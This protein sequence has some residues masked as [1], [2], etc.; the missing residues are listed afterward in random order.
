LPGPILYIDLDTTIRGDIT[1]LLDAVEQH[2]FI[3]L[4]NPYPTPS[5]FGSGLM[6]W[7]GDMSHV[8]TRFASDPEFHIKRCTT[9]ALWGDQGF[10][11]E[12]VPNPVLWQDLFPGE[13]VSWKAEC[14]TGVPE[15][16]RVVY[17]H[18]E[19]RPWAVG[20]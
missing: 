9:Q 4:R 20:M 18:G 12:D 7:R 3:A 14:K 17:F 5:R 16:A 10:I 1:P 8:Y 6:G 2:D 11:A 15:Q 19:P 13:I